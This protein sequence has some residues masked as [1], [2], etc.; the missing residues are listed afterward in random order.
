MLPNG[1]GGRQFATRIALKVWANDCRSADVV[2]ATPSGDVRLGAPG[3]EPLIAAGQTGAGGGGGVVGDGALGD[4]DGDVPPPVV[5]PP[6]VPPE[7]EPPEVDAPVDVPPPV[8]PSESAPL[9]PDESGSS[10]E[11]SPSLSEPL[12]AAV[13]C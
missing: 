10:D 6:V 3:V 4:G 1:T 9:A 11:V 5:P 13:W 7:L 12:S 8:D 2:P